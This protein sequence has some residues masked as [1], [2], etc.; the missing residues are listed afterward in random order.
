[1]KL[2]KFL[3]TTPSF[4]ANLCEN[5]AYAANLG[6]TKIYLRD[7]FGCGGGGE[8][9]GSGESLRG[10]SCGGGFRGENLEKAANLVGDF[11]KICGNFGVKLFVNYALYR[12]FFSPDSRESAAFVFAESAA[13]N[14]AP[15]VCA[16]N[17]APAAPLNLGVHLK[18]TELACKKTLPQ[19]LATSHSA[20]DLDALIAAYNAGVDFIFLS[21]IFFVEG[22][23]TPLG[24]DY[25][26]NIPEIYRAKIYALGGINLANIALF[27]GLGILGVAGIRTFVSESLRESLA[28]KGKQ[29]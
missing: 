20:H 23:G 10:E 26:K 19:N 18:S 13:Q 28:Q 1:M 6:V 25:L 27:E 2:D 21:P 9:G 7:D 16:K 3:I 17:A 14:L 15:A 11:L 5:I 8:S 24:L 12:A 4:Y 29:C 22:K